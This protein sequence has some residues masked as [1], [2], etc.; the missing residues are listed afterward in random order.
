MHHSTADHTYCHTHWPHPHTSAQGTMGTPGSPAHQH[1]TSLALCR[2][3]RVQDLSPA[4]L[5]PAHPAPPLLLVC[6]QLVVGL[7]QLCGISPCPQHDLVHSPRVT[8]HKPRHII[9]LRGGGGQRS[10]ETRAAQA[11]G[12][13][14]LWSPFLVLRCARFDAS[15]AGPVLPKQNV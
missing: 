8:G 1:R 15:S 2:G 13:R 6:V 12:A 11:S 9:H 5:V 10:R 14:V 7:K 4:S 3:R